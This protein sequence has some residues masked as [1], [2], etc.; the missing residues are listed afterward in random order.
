[1][2]REASQ[3][4]RA[5]KI[6][7]AQQVRASRQSYELSGAKRANNFEMRFSLF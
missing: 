7:E 3:K 6:T 2:A 5:Q 1:M 4:S